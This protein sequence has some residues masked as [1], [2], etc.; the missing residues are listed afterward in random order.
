M[1]CVVVIQRSIGVFLL[2]L[3]GMATGYTIG[4]MKR[5]VR[6]QDEYAISVKELTQT[7]RELS[8][9]IKPERK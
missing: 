9:S 5:M 3:V 7:H 6:E 2:L 4:R 8:F 1:G